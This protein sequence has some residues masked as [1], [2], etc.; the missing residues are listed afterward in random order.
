MQAFSSVTI[1]CDRQRSG[2]FDDGA[3]YLEA[4]LDLGNFEEACKLCLMRSKLY[5]EATE[6]FENFKLD[7][8]IRAQEYSAIKER[9]L[10]LFHS[11]E[12]ISQRSM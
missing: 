11:T 6:E 4:T 2:R 1:F 10:M 7:N 8:P 3:A 5:R 12:T 9:L